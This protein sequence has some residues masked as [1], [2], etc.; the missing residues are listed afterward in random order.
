MCSRQHF[1]RVDRAGIEPARHLEVLTKV[2]DQVVVGAE[3]LIPVRPA[4]LL[5]PLVK[6]VTG[7]FVP[8]E[9]RALDVAVVLDVIDLQNA[10]VIDPAHG[11]GRAVP[12]ECLGLD[13]PP[14]QS[15]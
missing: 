1:D 10:N 7:L 15:T 5:Q 6:S 12:I 13:F 3:S 4:L 11:A 14:R 8:A 9:R 2:L